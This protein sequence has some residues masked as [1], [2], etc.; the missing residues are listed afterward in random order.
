MHRSATSFMQ[1]GRGVVDA[2]PP[3]ARDRV[4]AWLGHPGTRTVP[5]EALDAELSRAAQLF[6]SSEDEA[7]AL[8]QGFEL[9]V[10]EDRPEDPFSADYR[11][12]TW[13]LYRALSGHTRYSVANEAS[14]I[15]VE[16]ATVRPFPFETGSATVV[17]GDLVARGHL[18]RCIGEPSYGLRPPARI[19]EFGP[20]WGNLTEDL[21][22]TGFRVTAVEV[23]A[24]FCE[25]IRRRCPVP[26]LLT[27]TQEDM[28]S[29]DP[30]DP[31]DAAIFFES[32][33]HCSNHL[34]ML[35][36][37]HRIVR[38]G[39]PVF[40][41]SEPVQTMSYPWGPRLD[42]LSV[43]S[44]RTYGWLELGFD[45]GYFDR[46]LSRTGWRGSWHRLGGGTSAHDV[47]V[48]TDGAGPAGPGA[49]G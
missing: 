29:F 5:L 47:L 38:P 2:L 49:A 6:A 17:G 23:D 26:E 35:A 18:M 42:G 21:V 39:G 46:A 48:A 44:T 10:P 9:A 45:T 37:L 22:A 14:P 33:H 13:R 28:L 24:Q 20:G 27:V 7:R 12:W 1:F 34:Q 31:F 4:R 16:R 41:A 32:F 3:P 43:W 25:L 15:D 8:L 19:V 30:G 36:N 40:F 11:E